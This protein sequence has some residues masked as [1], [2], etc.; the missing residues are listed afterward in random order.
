MEAVWQGPISQILRV[1]EFE[2][3][4][5][6]F[7]QPTFPQDLFGGEVLFCTTSGDEMSFFFNQT[8]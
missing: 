1:L 3:T 6:L 7:H 2:L 4:F 8:L 5:Q